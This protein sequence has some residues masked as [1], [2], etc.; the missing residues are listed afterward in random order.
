MQK[1]TKNREREHQALGFVLDAVRRHPAAAPFEQLGGAVVADRLTARVLGEDAAVV[2]GTLELCGQ[3]ANTGTWELTAVCLRTDGKWSL[4]HTQLAPAAQS[5]SCESRAQRLLDGVPAGVCLC[6]AQKRLPILHMNVGLL[7]L[8]GHTAQTLHKELGGCLAEVVVP[9]CRAEMTDAIR[10]QLKCGDTACWECRMRHADGAERSVLFKA[11][12]HTM[13]DG[14]QA[15]YCVLLDVTERAEARQAML[16][17]LE[18]HR[19]VMNQTMDIVFEWDIVKDVLL[20][21][22]NWYKKLGVR[23]VNDKEDKQALVE[24]ILKEDQVVLRRLLEQVTTG[25][26]YAESELRL[27]AA[28]G[29][30]LWCRIRLTT[31]Y[32]E[33][34]RPVR[35]VGV[36]VDI[37]AEKRQKQS[38]MEQARRDP[39][40]GLLNKEAARREV[41]WR[42]SSE[43]LP[44]GVL[45]IVDLDNFKKINDRCGHLCGDKVITEVAGVLT[46]LFRSGD[47]IAR[48]G[49]DEFMV[50]LS[51]MAR[52]DAERKARELTERLRAVSVKPFRDGISCSVGVA[53]CPGDAKSYRELYHRADIALYQAKHKGKN[54]VCCYVRGQQMEAAE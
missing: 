17:S 9:A 31:C 42:L 43:K 20:F 10:Q 3:A 27:C 18:R 29:E 37:D 1:E 49:G 11:H 22:S 23:V 44:T 30:T 7:N 19:I 28:E 16:Q 2:S 21:S 50:Y 32:D 33:M 53:A 46:R 41:E 24:R 5:A 48:V 13:D 45:L 4:A 52:G 14:R 47:V 36:I 39:L 54:G 26:P 35:A 25:A 15:L 38:L 12:L 40:T 6:L 51:G 34:G 8:L